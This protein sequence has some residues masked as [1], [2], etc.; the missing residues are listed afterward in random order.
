MST[1]EDV[2]EMQTQGMSEED[3]IA[4]LQQNGV[5]YKEIS[6]A[7]SQSKIK[8]AIEQPAQDP[9]SQ[10]TE[11][12][13]FMQTPT[14]DSYS[15]QYMQPQA[16]QGMEQSIMQSGLEPEQ[17]QEYPMY[18]DQNEG[19]GYTEGAGYSQYDYTSPAMSADTMTEIAEQIVSE[20]LIDIR[21]KIENTMNF[22]TVFE[23]K[24]EALEERLKRIEKII[25]ALQS[26]V[27]RKVGDYVTDVNDIKKELIETQKSFAKLP[28][29]HHSHS[30]HHSGKSKTRHHK[31]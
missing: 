3:I 30:S 27:L 20:K 17:S 8:S 1:L 5:S 21:K 29:T 13:D 22:K 31:Q 28:H 2:K 25:D 14:A 23:T 9:E 10:F 19:Y 12:Q 18:Q 24:A 26:S 16:P 7:L 11:S 15:E 6:D 4:S